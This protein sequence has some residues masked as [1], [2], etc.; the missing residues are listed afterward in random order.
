[1]RRLAA[2]LLL[3]GTLWAPQAAVAAVP[4]ASFYDVERSVMCIS[5]N[6]SLNIAESPQADR[7]RAQIRTLIAQGLTK[8]QILDRLVV[9]YG[10]PNILAEP[11]AEGFNVLAY[12]VPL[13]TVLGLAGVGLVL[14]PRWRRTRG[15]TASDDGADRDGAPALSADDERR[16]DAELSRFGA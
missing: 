12:G 5:C 3:L 9:L 10:T 15:A 7:T 14:L 13:A 6:V 4:R 2:T 1:M 11:K 8:D 16:L